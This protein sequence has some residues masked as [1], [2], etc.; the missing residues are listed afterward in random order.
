MGPRPRPAPR[1]T[2]AFTLV[3]LMVVIVVVGLIGSVAVVTWASMLPKQQF[4]TA[5]RNLSEVLYGTRSEAIARSRPFDI[6]Y[7][8][9]EDSYRVRTP[10]KVGGGFATAEDEP[11]RLWTHATNLKAAGIELQQVTIDDHIF[12]DGKAYAY[13]TPVG[14]SC[15]HTIQLHDEALGQT[16]TLEVLPLTGEIRMHDGP[17]QR[18]PVDD[19]DFR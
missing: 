11:E 13:F 2:R 16:F 4:H 6:E 18:K 17:F 19:G 1:S 9:D 15:Y 12:S 7:D 5:I 3:E 8:L 10:Y 14:A